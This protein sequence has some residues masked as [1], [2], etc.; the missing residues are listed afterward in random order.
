MRATICTYVATFEIDEQREKSVYCGAVLLKYPRISSWHTHTHTWWHGCSSFQEWTSAK[1]NITAHLTA[2]WYLVR[3]SMWLYV[4]QPVNAC[5]PFVGW[6]CCHKPG[7]TRAPPWCAY[8]SHINFIPMINELDFTSS[9]TP[10]LL[11]HT[12]RSTLFWCVSAFKCAHSFTRSS[13]P[14]GSTT[15]VYGLSLV[16]GRV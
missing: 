11:V 14:L 16:D 7:H 2:Y 12:N 9:F 10:D 13:W 15:R 3:L 6:S 1:S 4:S 5:W 8:E